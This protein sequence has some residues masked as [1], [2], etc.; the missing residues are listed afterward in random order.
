MLLHNQGLMPETGGTNSGCQPGQTG[1]Y[2]NK[3]IISHNK[4]R[5]GRTKQNVCSLLCYSYQ[6]SFSFGSR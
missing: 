3:L 1:T 5:R 6:T 2:N 4:G